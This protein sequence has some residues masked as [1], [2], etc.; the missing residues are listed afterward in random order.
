MPLMVVTKYGEGTLLDLTE[1]AFQRNPRS[2]AIYLGS[3]VV[4]R[5]F[6]NTSCIAFANTGG[7]EGSGFAGLSQIAMPIMG[8]I[9][10]TEG[11]HEQMV[12]GEVDMEILQDAED[13]YKV[14]EDI[15]R[16]DFHYPVYAKI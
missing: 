8:D 9:A 11:A 10:K 7:P 6:E 5:A 14:R 3:I 2:E 4:S 12:I 16:P 13:S 15:S 1:P